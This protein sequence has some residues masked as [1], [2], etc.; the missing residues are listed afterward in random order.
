MSS[1][2]A[3]VLWVLAIGVG[4]IFVMT[5][6][7]ADQ[8]SNTANLADLANQSL[9][10]RA[11]SVMALQIDPAPGRAL[12]L[13]V[14]FEGESYTLDLAPYSVRSERYEVKVQVADGSYVT[15]DPGSV[16]TLRGKVRDIDD[17]V[18]A[19]S[20]LQEGLYAMVKLSDARTFF[21]EPLEPHVPGASADAYVVYDEKDAIPTGFSCATEAQQ[22]QVGAGET[23]SAGTACGAGLCVAEL[24]CDTDVEY[25]QTYVTVAATEARINSII[26]RV[27]VQYERDVQITHVITTIIVRTIEPDPYDSPEP[28]MLLGEVRAHWQSSQGGV[29]RDVVQ[30]FTGKEFEQA[31]GNAFGAAMCT[32]DHYSWVESDFSPLFSCVVDV[33][34]HELG[35]LWGVTSHCSGGPPDCGTMGPSSGATECPNFFAPQS[36]QTITTFRDSLTCLDGVVTSVCEIATGSCCEVTTGSNKY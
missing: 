25:F 7:I 3:R 28:G 14:A 23:S 33:S 30:M 22:S 34:A 19:G 17:S 32:N 15:A 9:G 35:H 18:V 29:Q 10:L 36:I 5:T 16:R 24:A 2:V 1:S 27:N 8:P 26:N 21:I 13:V 6:T 20:L 11:S 4:V 31:H 12:E